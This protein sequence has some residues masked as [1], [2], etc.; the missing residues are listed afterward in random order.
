MSPELERIAERAR[1]E[2]KERFTALSH[3]LTV[4]FLRETWQGLNKRGSRGVDGVSMAA[5]GERLEENLEKL[6][7]DLKAHRYRAPLVRRVYIPKAGNPAKKRPLGIP[8]VE[9]RLLQ[10]AVSRLLGPIYEANFL[11][12]SY[13][14]RPGRTAH[15]ALTEVRRTVENGTAHWVVEADIQGFFNLCRVRHKLNYAESP[16]MPSGER[17]ALCRPGLGSV[18][19]A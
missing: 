7:A 9:D 1:K 10:A 12:C 15:Q 14:F 4:G 18:N 8:T 11:D 16:I 6:V 2:P 3:H 13:G 19:S 5:Y 17:E